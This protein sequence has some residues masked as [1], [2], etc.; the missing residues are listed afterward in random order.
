MPEETGLDKRFGEISIEKQWITEENL[1]R[2]LV[3]RRAI[4]NRT[5]VHTPIGKVLQK[6][7]LMTEEQVELV[8]TEQKSG[9]STTIVEE[10]ASEETIHF[11]DVFDLEI[12]DDKLAAFLIPTGLDHKSVT[13]DDIH[14]LLADKGITFGLVEE[15]SL[16][17]YLEASPLSP[18]PFKVATG[19]APTPKIPPDIV[20]H[21][22]T[23]P[24]R[25]GTLKTDGTMD[26]KDRGEIPQVAIGDLLVEKVGGDPGAPGTN[27]FEQEVQPPRIKEEKFKTEKGAQ[28]SEDGLQV[29]AKISGMP[30]LEADGRIAV[31]SVLPINGD[32]GLETGHVEFEGHIEVKGD[33]TSGYQVKGKSLSAK[34]IQKATIEMSE[35]VV[36]TGGIYNSMLKVGGSLKANHIHHCTIELLG[37]LVV[38]REIFGCTIET[39]GQVIIS[40]GKII[41][42]KVGAKKGIQTK[43][44]GT[45]ASKPSEITIGI[46][47]KLVRDMK[48]L[49]EELTDLE[50][51]KSETEDAVIKHKGRIDALADE[52]G[53]V[54]QEQDNVMVQKRNL[55]E[56]LDG[57]P[58]MENMQKRQLLT[59]MI[60]ELGDKYNELDKKVH[61]IMDQDEQIRL[62][63]NGLVKSLPEIDQEI[64]GKKDGI[65]LLEE[66]AKIDPGFPVI[67]ASGTVYSKTLVIGP[68]KKL[69]IDQDLTRVRIAESKDDA[70]QYQ[71]K[72]SAL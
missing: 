46:D 37:T 29:T 6:M 9:T 8:L 22:D 69:T 40:N 41:A 65:E 30:R 44:I 13:I 17:A 7:G 63:V 42:S 68:H 71:I 39:N 3:I 18:V 1:E 32:I 58:P 23:D 19:I 66:A 49:K 64:E 48:V 15:K 53:Q 10:S 27:I 47:H 45:G 21:F 43:D 67:K 55:E 24:L 35:D 31:Y 26:W 50:K 72:T 20:F 61:A 36:S 38:E 25:I 57:P 16:S 12:S 5:K 11:S 34:E 60:G 62:L 14:Q 2:A 4:F 51:R 28:V 33:V 59:E 70:N 56:K 52:L 54:A